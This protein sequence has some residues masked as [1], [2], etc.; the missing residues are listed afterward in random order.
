M[1]LHSRVRNRNR[2]LA[3]CP[4]K[5]Q[6]G[7][8]HRTRRR[9]SA[10]TAEAGCQGDPLYLSIK[11]TPCRERSDLKN[12]QCIRSA[13]AG[14]GMGKTK[15]KQESPCTTGNL[16]FPCHNLTQPISS[17]ELHITD[18]LTTGAVDEKC[19][20]GLKAWKI[21]ATLKSVPPCCPLPAWCLFKK[22]IM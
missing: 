4:R 12:K 16:Y 17:A 19:A 22:W 14:I 6:A 8:S 21:L 2:D 5:W 10:V 18:Q 1:C 3:G 13:S 15:Q 9:K 7:S 20:A 11:G